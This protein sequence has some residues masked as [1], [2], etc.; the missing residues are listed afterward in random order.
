MGLRFTFSVP[1]TVAAEWGGGRRHGACESGQTTGVA[2]DLRLLLTRISVTL[3]VWWVAFQSSVGTLVSLSNF[4]P[5]CA[6]RLAVRQTLH[7]QPENEGRKSGENLTGRPGAPSGRSALDFH[8]HSG[9]QNQSAGPTPPRGRLGKSICACAGGKK[10]E[11]R[12]V[13]T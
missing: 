5:L 3:V 1:C 10:K 4:P 2:G 11:T 7:R 13:N 8:L 9:G 12:Q 6:G